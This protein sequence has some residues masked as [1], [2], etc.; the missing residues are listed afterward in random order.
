MSTRAAHPDLASEQEFL[1]HAYACLKAMRDQAAKPLDAGGDKK[2][3]AALAKTRRKMR[4]RLE[5]PDTVA[6]GRI[7]F[8]GGDTYYVGPRSVNDGNGGLVV[9]NWAAPAAKPFYEATPTTPDGLKLRRRL[10]TERER[11][12]GISDEWFG[13]EV[14]EP[15]VVDLILDEL[16]RERTAEMRQVAA[17]IQQDQY[18]IIERPIDSA[19]IVQGGPGTGKTVVGLHRAAL[20]LFRH[21]QDLAG[22][23]VLVVGPNPLFMKYIA[24]V[25]PSLG[26]TAAEQLA[27]DSLGEVG[28]VTADDRLVAQVKGDQRMAEVLRRAVADR[29]RPP[30]EDVRIAANGVT[31]AISRDAVERLIGAFDARGENYNAARTRFR[32][33]LERAADEAYRVEFLRRRPGTVPTPVTIRTLPDFERALDR[34]WPTM[35]APDL[36]RQLLA[37][38][39][40]LER[41]TE[42]VLKESERRLLYR[43]PV[44]RL[45]QV[46]WSTSDVPLVDEVQQ[47]IGPAPRRYG[48]VVLDEAQDLTPMQLRMV[49]RRIRDGS[50]T[51]LG[52]LAQS[53]GL[54]SYASWDE[55]ATHLGVAATADIEELTLAYRVPREIMD[56]ALPVLELTAPSIHPPRAFRD[57][58][59]EPDFGEVPRAD[60][61]RRAIDA[62]VAAHAAGGTAAIIAPRSSLAGLREELEAR[63]LEFGDAERGELT[64]GIDLLDPMAAKGLEFDHV[65]LVEPAAIIREASD[66]RGHQ[67]LYVAVTRAMRTLTCLH[68]EPLPWPLNAQ[69][70]PSRPAAEPVIAA[71]AEAP[72]P[73]VQPAPKPQPPQAAPAALSVGEALVLA[74]LRGIE[75]DHALARA[76]IAHVRGESEAAAARAAL[77]ADN[78]D[79]TAAALAALRQLI[80]QSDEN[81]SG[82]G[83]H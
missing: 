60:R 78:D 75:L 46:R 45:D 22:A 57:G 29:V 82:R 74:R 81:G 23:R 51:V 21:Q 26:E 35:S 65:V 6:F 63:G 43:K 55:I 58:G 67:S 83:S 2:A 3:S 39:E 37:S 80:H 41:A 59:H 54:W 64:A 73:P 12:L 36:V 52:D 44:E 16:G 10:T 79:L 1:N 68:C 50:C 31:F 4:E 70:I 71:P 14:A 33:A 48:H 34:I 72:A 25:L 27:V 19:T 7:D 49:A 11:L 53:T 77:A 62:A 66:G 15:T 18:R 9:I 32:S 8:A 76:L 38:D 61:A 24:Y 13:A 5:N 20:L 28:A 30:T 56:V 42:G 17:T 69:A 40:R 47:L